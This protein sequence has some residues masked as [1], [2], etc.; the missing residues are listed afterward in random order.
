[1]DERLPLELAA[2]AQEY[3]LLAIYAFG[4][5]ADETAARVAGRPT[6][7]A[8]PTSDVDIGVE[9]LRGHRL[10]AQAR[11]RVMHR[12]EAL[13]AVG[14]VD[15]V[16]LPEADAFLA[17]DVVRGELLLATDLDAEADI[18]L[19][20]LARAANLAPFLREQW[21]DMVGSEP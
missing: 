10:D 13:L 20:Y 4:S 9:S 5:W 16:I 17:A 18:Q 2:L 3:G 15:L 6:A 19:Y 1:M 11:V 12:L 8:Y 14:R 21:Y 7:P